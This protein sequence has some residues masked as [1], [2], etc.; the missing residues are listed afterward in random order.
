MNVAPGLENF[1]SPW[2][3]PLPFVLKYLIVKVTHCFTLLYKTLHDEISQFIPNY[4]CRL[5]WPDV[6]F[7][8]ELSRRPDKYGTGRHI[9]PFFPTMPFYFE[10]AW[11]LYVI[12]L[13]CVADTCSRF[14]C[15][16]P[17]ID[18]HTDHY[19]LSANLNSAER[20]YLE[21]RNSFVPKVRNICPKGGNTTST[22]DGN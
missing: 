8:S 13:L 6:P 5:G 21:P 1:E 2:L 19:F 16:I 18:I 7:F 15:T 9:A 17:P 14:T 22:S 20:E 12:H 10:V 3:R 11:E 4:G